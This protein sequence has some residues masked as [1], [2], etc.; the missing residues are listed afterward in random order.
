MTLK[1]RIRPPTNA[2]MVSHCGRP[3][4]HNKLLLALHGRL[5]YLPQELLVAPGLPHLV[6]HLPVELELPVPGALELFEDDLVHPGAG[7]DESRGDN[8][9][10][11]TELDIPSRPEETLRWVQGGRV[12]ATRQDP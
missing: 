3:R 1:V 4:P 10:R 6:G 5:G 7:L 9:Q 2:T 11:S 8:S 12:D